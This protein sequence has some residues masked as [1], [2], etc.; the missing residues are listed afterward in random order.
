MD[1]I[2]NGVPGKGIRVL[3]HQLQRVGTRLLW[4]NLTRNTLLGNV[5]GAHT[6][7]QTL[8]KRA[9]FEQVRD[10]DFVAAGRALKHALGG[11]ALKGCTA[12]GA[13]NAH[14]RGLLELLRRP[15]IFPQQML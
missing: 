12:E 8:A 3:A 14:V 5:F 13:G 4:G 7:G 1:R 10:A 2:L 6:H 11:L 9:R 15:A